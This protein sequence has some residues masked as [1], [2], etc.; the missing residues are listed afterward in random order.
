MIIL[1]IELSWTYIMLC[2]EDL[3]QTFFLMIEKMH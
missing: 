1:L 2:D 3:I